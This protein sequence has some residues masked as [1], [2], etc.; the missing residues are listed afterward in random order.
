MGY[1]DI[2]LSIVLFILILLCVVL[3]VGVI[4]GYYY[5]CLLVKLLDWLNAKLGR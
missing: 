3:P 1:G 4:L 2:M 5:I